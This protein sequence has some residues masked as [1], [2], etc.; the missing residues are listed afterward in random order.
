[1]ESNLVPRFCCFVCYTNAMIAVHTVQRSKYSNFSSA[2]CVVSINT[3]PAIPILP[4]GLTTSNIRLP[5]G[6][7]EEAVAL[8][9]E[10]AEQSGQELPDNH[11]QGSYSPRDKE[12]DPLARLIEIIL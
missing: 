5:W 9:A 10:N 12:F 2:S 3:Q 11:K 1:M 7:G 4:K 8:C 6:V